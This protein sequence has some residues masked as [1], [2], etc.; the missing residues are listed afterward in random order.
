MKFWRILGFLFAAAALLCFGL[1]I[2]RDGQSG[3][4][5]PAGQLLNAAALLLC[6]A[7]NRG[8]KPHGARCPGSPA[9]TEPNAARGAENARDTGSRPGAP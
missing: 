1:C 6:C 9:D 8:A 4:L 5:L 7:A 3:L 2:L